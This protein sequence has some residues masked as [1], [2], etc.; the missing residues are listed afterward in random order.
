MV[1]E[2][3]AA[4]HATTRPPT[5]ALPP[6]PQTPFPTPPPPSRPPPSQVIRSRD[7]LLD[8]L[9]NYLS[10]LKPFELDSLL[11]EDATVVKR[12]SAAQQA[13]KDLAAAVEEVEQVKEKRAAGASGSPRAPTADVSVRSLL[14]G[15]A[16]PLVPKDKVP[17]GV[18]PGALYGDAT[19]V[20]LLAGGAEGGAGG[21][22]GLAPPVFFDMDPPM[23]RR[24]GM[25]GGMRGRGG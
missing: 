1:L 10:S 7:R 4:A 3:R 8:Q 23:V 6:R 5:H 17:V 16:F 24:G 14:L 22:G 15:G 9:Y 25:G 18:S 12:R 21:G 11:A 20:T 13:I 2:N 19:P